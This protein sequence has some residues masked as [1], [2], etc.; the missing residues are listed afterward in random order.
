MA[1]MPGLPDP[2]LAPNRRPFP[3]AMALVHP[4]AGRLEPISC[5]MPTLAPG[6]LRLRVRTCGVCR[7]DLHLVDGDLA[8]PELPRIPGHEIVGTVVEAG[9]G[10]SAFAVGDRVG[11]PWLSSTCGACRY[12]LGGRENLCADAR[13]TGWQIDGGYA[14]YAVV[15]AAAC[16]AI[17]PRFDDEQAAPLLCAGLIGYRAW[18]MLPGA[19]VIG[20][21]GFGAAAHLIAQVAL[22][23]GQTVFAFTRPGDAAAQV[24]A[25]TLG[26]HW[27]GD[28]RQTP[29]QPLDGAILFAPAGELV[30]L[31]LQ[32]LA[33]GGSVVCAGIHM[34]DIP[35][36]PYCWLW[37]ERSIRSVA[38]LTRRDAVDFMAWASTHPLRMAVHVYP[39]AQANDALADLRSGRIAGAAVLRCDG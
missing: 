22:A 34:S 39:L 23:E 37:M 14:D 3:L 29:P 30:P 15:P 17:P 24:L 6:Q 1:R 7:T 10:G 12:C 38:N 9:V 2:P 18:R 19:A 32:H 13:F 27:A 8:T 11:V 20:L 31:A 36:F 28:T 21:Y 33:P 5:P 4:G 35:S 25:R 26:V 16:V